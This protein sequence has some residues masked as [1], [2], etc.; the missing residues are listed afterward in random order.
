[1]TG[2][3]DRRQAEDAGSPVRRQDRPKAAHTLWLD[4]VRLSGKARLFME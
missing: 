1:M 3:A 4:A 2:T